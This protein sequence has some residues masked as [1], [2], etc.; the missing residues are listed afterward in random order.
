MPLTNDTRRPADPP[1][2]FSDFAACAH[3]PFRESAGRKEWFKPRHD[4]T[5]VAKFSRVT[6]LISANA[7]A[8]GVAPEFSSPGLFKHAA[9]AAFARPVFAEFTVE[10][11]WLFY[12]NRAENFTRSRRQGAHV[13]VI[14]RSDC[15]E[16]RNE[17]STGF[18]RRS[19]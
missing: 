11:S 14:I 19:F 3:F 4:S 2:S 6:R 1:V 13:L 9:S 7:A 17:P 10:R 16:T 15:A 18:H 12:A 8:R 5:R